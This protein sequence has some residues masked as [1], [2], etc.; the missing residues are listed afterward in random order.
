MMPSE[1][2]LIVAVDTNILQY[3]LA[4]MEGTQSESRTAY[5]LSNVT[6]SGGKLVIPAPVWAEYLVYAG[7]VSD[8]ISAAL[9]LKRFV[10]FGVFD[11][12]AAIECSRLKEVIERKGKNPGVAIKDAYQKVKIDRQ[13]VSIS[14]AC[15]AGGII[16]NDAA[17]RA[18]ASANGLHA[19]RLEDLDEDP[20]SMQQ[21][22]L[23]G[24]DAGKPADSKSLVH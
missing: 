14:I 13:I 6:K 18:L 7:R 9:L 4:N 22:L 20:A 21:S 3:I 1:A 23:S 11:L 24:L 16:S 19:Q 10:K 12:R 17:L 2:P 5:L 15:S 8:S